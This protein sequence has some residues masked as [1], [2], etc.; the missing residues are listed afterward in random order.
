MA[1]QPINNPLEYS[2]IL[3]LLETSDLGHADTFNPLFRILINNDAYLKAVTEELGQEVADILVD[4]A[5][6]YLMVGA[7]NKSVQETKN[8][9]V[10][11]DTRSVYI[12]REAGQIASIQVK[13]SVD[14]STIET[15]SISR[16]DGQLTG[17]SKVVNGKTITYT[18]NRS[19]GQIISITKGVE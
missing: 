13:D 19:D 2:E 6:A 11:V 16:T 12:T 15:M 18:I 17:V 8:L 5:G 9:L 4:M 1:N 7:D 14:N 10:D 3:R